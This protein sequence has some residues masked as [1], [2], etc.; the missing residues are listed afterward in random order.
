MPKK[1]RPERNKAFE[2][3]KQNNCKISNKEIA[4]LLNVPETLISCWKIRDSWDKKYTAFKNTALLESD[5]IALLQLKDNNLKKNKKIP[6]SNPPK[7]HKNKNIN[8]NNYDTA[9]TTRKEGGQPG[10]K[11]AAG[12]RGG[13]GAPIGNKHGVKTGELESILLANITDEEELQILNTPIDKILLQEVQI[14]KALIREH[15]MMKRIEATEKAEGGLVIDSVVKNVGTVT[16]TNK[17]KDGKPK[18]IIE[19]DTKA[20]QTSVES[21]AKRVLHLEE[22]LT[23]VS[24]VTQ[25]AISEYHK[26]DVDRDNETDNPTSG[27]HALAQAIRGSKQRVE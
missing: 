22:A 24:N 23:R 13:N 26:M 11:N 2:L 21:S 25:K 15:R 6:T 27:L 1:R 10:N 5:A 18:Y 12:G 20:T 3:Y 4:K 14:K 7:N 9:K 8:T 19:E 16:T 17:G